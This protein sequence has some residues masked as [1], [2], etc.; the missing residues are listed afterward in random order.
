L[1]TTLNTKKKV[2][3]KFFEP[4]GAK[5]GYYNDIILQKEIL[6]IFDI[7]S[8]NWQEVRPLLANVKEPFAL[9][10]SGIVLQN[11]D[12]K[13]LHNEHLVIL[14]FIDCSCIPNDSILLSLSNCKNLKE[15]TLGYRDAEKKTI[16]MK[17]LKCL[18]QIS[19]LRIMRMKDASLIDF[20]S[21]RTLPLTNLEV[22]ASSLS[23]DNVNDIIAIDGL[24]S[25]SFN[26]SSFSN[27]ADI[28]NV[29]KMKTL[30]VLDLYGCEFDVNILDAFIKN[31]SI[32]KIRVANTILTDEDIRLISSHRSLLPEI[33]GTPVSAQKFG[34]EPKVIDLESN[35]GE[36]IVPLEK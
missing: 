31:N 29:S 32:G 1:Y 4:T 8:Q 34:N 5:V 16:D 14:A 22:L 30:K 35:T 6:M 18:H 17:F 25:L 10:L 11:D 3:P 15:V 26:R 24:I 20:E 7:T 36:K 9:H 23:S 19:S 27:S 2:P 12:I 21:A 33:I 13:Q 28:R